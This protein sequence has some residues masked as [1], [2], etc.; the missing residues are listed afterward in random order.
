MSVP[1][2]AQND[3][4]ALPSSRSVGNGDLS[5]RVKRRRR[6]VDN[7]PHLVLRLGV[8]G[9]SLRLHVLHMDEFTCSSSAWFPL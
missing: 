8:H 5:T 7:L 2:R 4:G 9:F 1:L 3:S 6:E